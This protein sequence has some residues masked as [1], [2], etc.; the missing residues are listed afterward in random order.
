MRPRSP[1]TAPRPGSSFN[2]QL[3]YCR[4]PSCRS[5]PSVPGHSAPTRVVFQPPTHLPQAAELQEFALGPRPQRPDQG[6]LS[7]PNSPTAGR[8]AAG[9]RPRSPATAP[10]PGSSFNPQLTYLRPPSRRS[11]PS[12]P[13]HS[14]PT[15][16]VFQPP[17]HLPQAAELQEFALGPRPQRPDQGRLST[18]NSP[19][20]GR[21]AAGVRPR[22]L[23]TAPRPGSS[24]NPQLTYCRPLSRRS[25]LSVPGHSAPTRVVFQPPTHL[26][27]PAKPQ[28]F[29][30]GPRPQRPDQ[31]RLSTP[32]SPTAGRRAAG[33]R[34]RSPAAAPRPG[35]SFNPQLTYCRLLSRRSS[36]SVPGHSAPTRVV[37]QPLTHLLQ[38]AE[39][40]EFALGPRP[41]RPDQGRL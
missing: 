30:L 21:R 36:P 11:S 29:A 9:V 28:E 1:A 13:G 19:T 8:R 41:Q 22:S 17:T 15:R 34:P 38:A 20:S 25:S 4:P 26:L 35:S 40:Q 23:A 3:I 37:F 32:N 18:T 5:S 2:P 33:V 31:G 6:R 24:F 10:R 14:A 27:Q 7:T 16:V 39:P 12:V